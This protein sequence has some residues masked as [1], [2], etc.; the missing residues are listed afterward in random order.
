MLGL[1]RRAVPVAA[2]ALAL[3]APAA[4]SA[5]PRGSSGSH[6]GSHSGSRSGGGMTVAPPRGHGSGG[7]G[8]YH[9]GGYHSGGYRWGRHRGWGGFYGPYWSSWWWWGSPYWGWGPTVYIYDDDTRGYGRSRFGVVKTDVSPDE[10]EVYLDGKYIGTADDFDGYPDFLY[11]QPGKYHI[12][13]QLKGYE[14]YA[15]DIEIGRGET[16]RFNQRLKLVP[17]VSKLHELP[18]SKGMPHGRVFGPGAVPVTPREPAVR[19][20]RSAEDEE[21]DVD[22]ERDRVGRF[23]EDEDVPRK[24][25]KG[26]ARLGPRPEKATLRLKVTPDDAAV[27]V[28]DKYVGTGAEVGRTSEGFM[29][30]PGKRSITIVRPGYKARTIEVD[31]KAGAKVDVVVELEK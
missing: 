30:A 3:A 18:P 11:L 7:G 25:P 27:Y 17:G 19:D 10:A 24:A 14:T 12:E 6:S 20:R 22:V 26:D 13:F 9:G 16:Q 29:A 28:D 8:S 4:L 15:T 1:T 2:L 21:P 31:A 5:P 23:D